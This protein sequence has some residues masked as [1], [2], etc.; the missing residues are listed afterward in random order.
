VASIDVPEPPPSKPPT[1]GKIQK[2]SPQRIALQRYKSLDKFRPMPRDNESVLDRSDS[3][4]RFK[5]REQQLK[6]RKKGKIPERYRPKHE[7]ISDSRV[8][9]Q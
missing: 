6:I 2:N 1:L 3:F 5:D 9:E 8:L 7:E 4:E